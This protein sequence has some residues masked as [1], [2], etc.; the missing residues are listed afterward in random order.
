MLHSTLTSP[1]EVL[2]CP[3]KQDVDITLLKAMLFDDVSRLNPRFEFSDTY[4]TP[5]GDNVTCRSS[6]SADQSAS[7]TPS[8]ISIG[9]E[10]T[11]NLQP[12]HNS[13]PT[14]RKFSSEPSL[15]TDPRRSTCGFMERMQSECLDDEPANFPPHGTS[16]NLHRTCIRKK[17]CRQHAQHRLRHSNSKS[18]PKFRRPLSECNIRLN[19]LSPVNEPATEHMVPSLDIKEIKS[20][21]ADVFLER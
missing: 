5:S 15:G 10:P 18:R 1:S 19:S 2:I 3:S 11:A 12:R 20:I 8:S 13:S 14:F 9:D 4:H 7:D 17:L 6:L 16:E 21:C